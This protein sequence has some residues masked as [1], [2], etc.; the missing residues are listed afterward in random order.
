M[1]EQSKEKKYIIF[2]PPDNEEIQI[3]I[4]SW[5]SKSGG[6]MPLEEI[7][8]RF[9]EKFHFFYPQI[10]TEKQMNTAQIGSWKTFAFRLKNEIVYQK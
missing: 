3:T 4:K 2:Q 10:Y 5:L 7:E 9:N 6:S 8:K 1:E